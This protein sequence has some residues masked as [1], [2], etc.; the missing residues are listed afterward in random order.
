MVPLIIFHVS[1]FPYFNVSRVNQDLTLYIHISMRKINT[2]SWVKQLISRLYL[3]AVFLVVSTVSV[4]E[5]PQSTYRYTHSHFRWVQQRPCEAQ[6]LKKYTYLY[7]NFK[8]ACVICG[9]YFCMVGTSR[10]LEE[11]YETWY[12]SAVVSVRGRKCPQRGRK[13]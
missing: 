6:Y 2:S 12:M 10:N 7:Q 3:S 11:C 4:P 1:T 13:L 5:T 8:S 9:I